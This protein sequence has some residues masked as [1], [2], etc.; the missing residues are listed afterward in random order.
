[1]PLQKPR[2]KSKKA[3]S[4]NI[5]ELIKANKEKPQGKQRPLKQILAIALSSVRKKKGS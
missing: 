2:G 5:R 4:A 1:M 3:V